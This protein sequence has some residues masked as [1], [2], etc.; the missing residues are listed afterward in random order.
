[1]LTVFRAFSGLAQLAIIG[2]IVIAILGAYAGW[3]YTI[4]KRGYD[5]AITDIAAE[6]KEAVDAANK[7]RIRVRECYASGGSWDQSG[8]MCQR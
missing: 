7:A 8:G 1:M 5:K 4:Y 6:N 3:H 2:G